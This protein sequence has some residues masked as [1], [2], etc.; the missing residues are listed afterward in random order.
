[1][2][3]KVMFP[4]FAASEILGWPRAKDLNADP[5]LWALTVRAVQ[6]VQGLDEHG[7]IGKA[8]QAS[9]TADSLFKMWTS[10]ENAML[11]LD[12]A[13][14]MKLHHGFK[15][16]SQDIQLLEDCV[17]IGKRQGSQMKALKQLLVQ[18]RAEPH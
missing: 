15:H 6:D 12:Y 7:S 4:V 1:M 10:L 5:E 16:R 3:T 11:P 8:A 2:M 13:E 14:F 9:L 17:D 18:L